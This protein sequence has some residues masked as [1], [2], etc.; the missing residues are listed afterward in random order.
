MPVLRTRFKGKIRNLP[1]SEDYIRN[2][3]GVLHV[4]DPLLGAVL[5]SGGQ[6]KS[7]PNRTGSTRHNV[8]HTGAANT[9]DLLLTLCDV[10]ILPGNNPDLYASFLRNAASVFPG[11]GHYEWGVHV[12]G[13]STAAWGPT[14]KATSLDPVFGRAIKQGRAPK[15]MRKPPASSI[16][17]WVR[18]AKFALRLLVRGN[19]PPTLREPLFLA[20]H[21]PPNPHEGVIARW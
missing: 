3:V 14:G 19:V 18:L 16:S 1:V 6:D 7:G 17:F 15:N 9:A 4:T 21:Q 10:E 5:T 2:L 13:G 8:D 11:I 20:L 12:G